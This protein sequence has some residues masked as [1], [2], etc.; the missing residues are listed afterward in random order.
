MITKF[1]DEEQEVPERTLHWIR[2]VYT[3]D[4]TCA[5]AYYAPYAGDSSDPHGRYEEVYNTWIELTD[6]SIKVSLE[7]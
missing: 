2:S 3:E 1:I 6:M 7:I 4:G 5:L